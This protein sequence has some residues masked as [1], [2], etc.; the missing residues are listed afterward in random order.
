[1]IRPKKSLGQNWLRSASAL[2]TMIKAAELQTSDTVLEIGPGQ[3]ALTE[4]LLKTDAAKIIAVEKDDRLISVL[5]E[6]FRAEIKT[7]RLELIHADILK[8][9]STLLPPRFKLIAN[10]PYYLTGQILRHF[11]TAVRPPSVAILML[12][13][14]VAERIVARDKRESLLSI[15]VKA[16]GEPKYL[17]TVPA[18]AFQ[19]APQVDSAILGIFNIKT[20]PDSDKLFAFLH[21]GFAHKRKLLKSN[22][23]CS[24]ADLEQCKINPSARAENLTLEQW[25]CL[26]KILS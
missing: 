22:L 16:F 11:L 19:P 3:G 14:E 10:L 4:A 8:L 20:S 18:G 24:T 26:A 12:Q 21:R 2:A 23:A 13:K 17:K 25:L 6:K 15:S 5:Q 7:G 1:M 9:S